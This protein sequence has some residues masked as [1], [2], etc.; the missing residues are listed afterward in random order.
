MLTGLPLLGVCVYRP[1][2][3]NYGELP[4][5]CRETFL[6]KR[7]VLGRAEKASLIES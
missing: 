3:E 7:I 1:I 6:R 4:V 5:R 2:R